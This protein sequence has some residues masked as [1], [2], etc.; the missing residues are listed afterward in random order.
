SSQK[1]GNPSEPKEKK[2]LWEK[3]IEKSL[4][5][6]KPKVAEIKDSV[7]E[8]KRNSAAASTEARN[9]DKVEMNEEKISAEAG[10]PGEAE[11]ERIRGIAGEK[12]LRKYETCGKG[13]GEGAGLIMTLRA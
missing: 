5:K 7:D 2:T 1:R 12:Y 9:Q 6:F 13:T 4:E 8:E 10:N 3:Q 11:L